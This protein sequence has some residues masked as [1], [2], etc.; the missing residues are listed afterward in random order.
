M[1]L[2]YTEYYY[3]TG[4]T[5]TSMATSDQLGG[6]KRVHAEYNLDGDDKVVF[7]DGTNY[8]ATFIILLVIL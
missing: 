5:W 7:V 2:N 3:G 1:L 8:P 6:G 4:T